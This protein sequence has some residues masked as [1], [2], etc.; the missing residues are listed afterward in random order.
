MEGESQR[1]ANKL[2]SNY[3]PKATSHTNVNY[4]AMDSDN[5]MT[6]AQKLH[7]RQGILKV[8]L[9]AQT[10]GNFKTC[11][12]VLDTAAARG[13]VR[14]NSP[15]LLKRD[16]KAE[17]RALKSL[18]FKED[19]KLFE[20]VAKGKP[21]YVRSFHGQKRM[22]CEDLGIYSH[23]QNRQIRHESAGNRSQTRNIT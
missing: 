1:A 3:S 11:K 16:S 17:K 5:F 19:A 13:A 23:N 20:A 22:T 8:T 9:E 18:F 14:Q 6:S 21:A 15:Y 2:D 7:R 10:K 4:T 12:A